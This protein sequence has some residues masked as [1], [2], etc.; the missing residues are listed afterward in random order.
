M[1]AAMCALAMAVALGACG[2]DAGSSDD[3]RTI[4]AAP[5]DAGDASGSD[6]AA[7]GPCVERTSDLPR[8]PSGALPCDLLPPGVA[9]P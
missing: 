4:D 3:A 5:I 1:R 7:V 8:P 9:A 2:D 6:A